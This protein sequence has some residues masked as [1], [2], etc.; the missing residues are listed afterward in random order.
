MVAGSY[1]QDTERPCSVKG[2]KFL[3]YMNDYQFFKKAIQLALK[4]IAC[5]FMRFTYLAR[6]CHMVL[7]IMDGRC[8]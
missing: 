6:L 1:E 3:K 8:T 5:V 2:V 4:C 7:K